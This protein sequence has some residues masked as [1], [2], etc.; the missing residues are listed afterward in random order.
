M[1]VMTIAT[2]FPQLS[3]C[4]DC[5]QQIPG[6]DPERAGQCGLALC[7]D[8]NGGIAVCGGGYGPNW[9]SETGWDT[10]PE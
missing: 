2:A 3:A 5:G 9:N 8:C 7:A 6:L 1:N 10:D 4:D